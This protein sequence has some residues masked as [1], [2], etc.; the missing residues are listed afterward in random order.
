M[1][2]KIAG[3]PVSSE[4]EA[5]KAAVEAEKA[6]ARKADSLAVVAAGKAIADSIAAVKLLDSL[7][8]NVIHSSAMGGAISD[9]KVPAYHVV[10]GSFKNMDN[11][12]SL[13]EQ[14]Q[15]SGY[16]AS[17][18]KLG[19]GYAAVTVCPSDRISDIADAYLRVSRESF[20]PRG[21]WIL[22]NSDKIL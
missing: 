4:I 21:A 12:G 11:A 13:L 19:N 22:N 6:A 16:P 5:V 7:K 15:A 18:L 9:V 3:R 1:F 14:V 17:I 20:C 2:R 8:V 10:V